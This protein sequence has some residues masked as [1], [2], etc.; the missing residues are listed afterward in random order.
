VVVLDSQRFLLKSR[1]K[2]ELWDTAKETVVGLAAPEGDPN[3]IEVMDGKLIVADNWV[4]VFDA[5]LS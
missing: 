3:L 1:K 2:L 4:E 5:K